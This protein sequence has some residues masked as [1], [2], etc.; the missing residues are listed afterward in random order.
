MVGLQ[1][2]GGGLRILEI[3]SSNFDI[4]R[5]LNP[6]PRKKMVVPNDGKA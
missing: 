3:I 1:I 5:T 2:R 6:I 4:P